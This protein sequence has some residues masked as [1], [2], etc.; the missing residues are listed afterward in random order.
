M[1][2]LRE[3]TK[4]RLRVLEG[5]HGTWHYHLGPKELRV[6]TS[7]CGDVVM[8]TSMPVSAWGT[9]THINERWCSRCA[10]KAAELEAVH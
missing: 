8:T 10:A 6:P 4:S 3:D 5:I 9:K 2:D 1:L 7:L